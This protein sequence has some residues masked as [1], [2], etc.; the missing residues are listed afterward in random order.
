MVRR[1]AKVIIDGIP[2]RPNIFNNERRKKI[3]CNTFR[4]YEYTHTVK[5]N[6]SYYLACGQDKVSS[7]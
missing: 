7:N 5:Y 6:F 2:C 4:T 3:I 1:N